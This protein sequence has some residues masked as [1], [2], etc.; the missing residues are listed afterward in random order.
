[1]KLST[2][3]L[4]AGQGIRMKSSLPK[5]LHTLLGHPLAWYALQAARQ[6]SPEK[7]VM[8]IGHGAGEVQKALGDQAEYVIQNHYSALGML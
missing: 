2:L 1:M 5:V 6:V 3:I 8:V 4:A 7:P